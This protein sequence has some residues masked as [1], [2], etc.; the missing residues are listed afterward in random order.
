MPVQITLYVEDLVKASDL[1]THA[2]GRGAVLKSF[3]EIEPPLERPDEETSTGGPAYFLCGG[4]NPFRVGSNRSKA[5]V[6][7][8]KKLD[9]ARS[10]SRTE[11]LETL[12]HSGLNE[13][14]EG[15]DYFRAML[16]N[17]ILVKET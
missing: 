16:K 12:K 4:P 2:L 15:E 9:M 10:Y 1:L 13:T 3:N 5:F 6:A 8:R 17:D 7:L 14:G 11:I